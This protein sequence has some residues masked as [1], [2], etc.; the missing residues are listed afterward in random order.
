[1]RTILY[2]LSYAGAVALSVYLAVISEQ[3]WKPL[4]FS[5]FYLSNKETLVI[6]AVLGVTTLVCLLLGRLFAKNQDK[7][8]YKKFSL[9]Y[10]NFLL[11]YTFSILYFLL[12]S[13]ITFN[14]NIYVYVGIYSTVLAFVIHFVFAQNKNNVLSEISLCFSSIFKR[15]TTLYGFI[16]ILFF[17]TPLVLAISFIFS[18]EVAD[19]ITEVRL[20]FN[21]AENTQWALVPAFKNTYFNRPMIAK[22]SAQ[23]KHLL[24][25]LERSGDLYKVDY[26]SGKNKTLVLDIKEKVGLVDIENGALGLALHPEFSIPGSNGY[27]NIYVYYTSVHD[28]I[29]KNIIS[30]FVLNTKVPASEIIE[31]DIMILERNNEAYHNGG[32]VEFG[33][34]GFLYI[35]L[36]EGTHPA[37]ETR[38]SKTLRAGIMRIDVDKQG[39]T[40]SSPID[41]HVAW[42]TT[43]N[44]FIPKDNPFVDDNDVLDE[45]WVMGLRNP[46]RISFD[47]ATGDLWAGDVGS[48]VWEEVNKIIK[49]NNYLYPYIEGPKTADFVV[50]KNLKGKPTHPTYTYK[51]SAFDRAVIGGVVYRGKDIPALNGVYL[52]GDNFSGK[53][54][55]IAT[56]KEQVTQVQFVAQAEQY[57]QRGISSVT[58]NPEGEIFVTLL[59][60]KNNDTGQ[61]M[62]LKVVN[63]A[64][65][66]K[67]QAIPKD[68]KPHVY[69]VNNTKSLFLEMCARCHSNTGDGKGPDSK[70]FNITIAD[71]SQ[72]DYR[73]KRST[74]DLLNIIK[75]GGGAND[76]SP[77]MPPWQFV[78]SENELNDLVLYIQSLSTST[79]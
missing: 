66:K 79:K 2:L 68:T 38:P 62:L 75:K 9:D 48:T 7:D 16:V 30:K 63:G 47:K 5:A 67:T 24:Y 22:F 33:P 44:Y 50:P 49:G 70:L 56:N 39:G 59:G 11:A 64:T 19:A 32:S 15:I 43:A 57:A 13:V 36:G 72:P 60:E 17:I 10:F 58:Y 52:F 18:R 76:L 28:D 55:G 45:Y 21:K 3:T 4:P 35:A 61:L 41:S 31:T 42:G 23:E 6:A 74:T 26:P 25:I 8:N 53:L 71:F 40:V 20:Q 27:Q 12:A 77:Y 46:F 65:N 14:P 73:Q 78:L 54:F 69:S 1:M 37:G 29:Q 34:D 51:H